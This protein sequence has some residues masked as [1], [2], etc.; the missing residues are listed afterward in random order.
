MYILKM[1]PYIII[2]A[3]IALQTLLTGCIDEE[4]TGNSRGDC[5]EALW[6]TVDER[7]CFFDVAEDRYGLDWNAVH[8][9]YKPMA[10]ACESDAELFDI[11]GEMLKELRDGHVNLVSVYGTSYYWDWKLNHPINFSDSIQ[12]NYLGNDFRL[13]NGIKYK[14]LPDSIGYIYVE[15]FG[16]DFR[17]NNLTIMLNNLK[18]CKGIVLDIRQ[19]GGGM[20]TAAEKLASVFTDERIHY[21]Y[22]RHKTGKGHH[23]L[24]EPEELYLEKTKTSK[25]LR[26]VVLLTNRGVYSA[27]NH[28]TMIM[29]ELPNVYIMGDVT[30]GGCGMPLSR[31]LPNGWTIRFSACPLIDIDGEHTEFGIEP[32]RYVSMTEA[33]W[34]KGRDTMI[35]SAREFIL[36]CYSKIS[37]KETE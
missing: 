25:W 30:G 23:D 9:K 19:N 1:K 24:S 2:T 4:H 15:S 34:N 22:I 17:N 37:D 18:N 35:E 3:I 6:S 32:D 11:M 16:S 13:T 20:L 29:R 26:P 21:G 36:G 14:E 31:T 33:D 5:F 12:R 10:E 7:Y 28:F 27:A 8:D